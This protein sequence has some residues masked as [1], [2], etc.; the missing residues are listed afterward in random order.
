[1]RKTDK[2]NFEKKILNEKFQS[3][4]MVDELALFTSEQKRKMGFIVSHS[5]DEKI[6]DPVMESMEKQLNMSPND[7]LDSINNKGYQESIRK[8]KEIM[9]D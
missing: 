3:E 9:E 1:M 2:D 4:K 6:T 5:G 8:I 7:I